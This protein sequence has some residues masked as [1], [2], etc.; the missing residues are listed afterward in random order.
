LKIERTKTMK[1]DPK[2]EVRNIEDKKWSSPEG[3][4][5]VDVYQ[6]DKEIIVRSAV[7]GVRVE[8]LDISVDNDV[9]LIKGK[10]GRPDQEE[11]ANYFI[12]E[13]YWGDFSRRIIIPDEIDPSRIDASMKEGILTIRI[14]RIVREPNKPIKIK[15][16]E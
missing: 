4:L 12:Q 16:R 2:W 3:E 7:A 11:G 9:L 8:D 6:I 13:C 5:A 1:K 10:R 14:P 15:K